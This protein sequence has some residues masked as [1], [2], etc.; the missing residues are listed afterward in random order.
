MR[1]LYVFQDEYPWD[2]RVEKITTSLGSAHVVHL[3]CRNRGA[4]AAEEQLGQLSVHRVGGSGLAAIGGFP[5]F[6]SPWWIRAGLS[7]IRR[8][9]IDLLIVRD[10]PL[11]PLALILKKFTGVPVIFDMAEDYPAMIEDTWRYRGPALADYLIR[12]PRLLRTMENLVLPR[13]D[14]TWVVSAASRDR[15][16]AKSGQGP[17]VR[18]I[19]NTPTIDIL[20]MK[21]QPDQGTLAMVYTGFIDATRGLDTVVRALSL[22]RREGLPATLD[23]VGTG[24]AL[25]DIE[26]LVAELGL[27]EFVTF[28]GWCTQAQLRSVIAACSIGV[29]PHR[30]TAHTSTT[31]PNKIFDYMALAKPVIVSNAR[32][33]EDVV[34]EAG[35]GLVF[36]D[37]DPESLLSCLRQLQA[38]ETREGMGAS[39]R[40]HVQE[41]LNWSRDEAVLLDA[42]RGFPASRSEARV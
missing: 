41:Q 24:A 22:A 1:I 28:H 35:C 38:R 23:V 5:A 25:E 18:V 27:D 14:E 4:L 7:V 15:V 19:G 6:F 16:M 29:V 21:P 17:R 32:A 3:L 36:Q 40:R 20:D 9:R 33:L 31:L 26:K 13:V 2:V 12:N 37:G 39:G 10:L 34:T 11:C 8:H 42:V 30:V